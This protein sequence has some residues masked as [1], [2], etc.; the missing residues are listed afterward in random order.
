MFNFN[1]NNQE[2]QAVTREMHR[3]CDSYPGCKG[4]P[5]ESGDP[6]VILGKKCCCVTAAM[7]LGKDGNLH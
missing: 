6:I 4:C 3:I 2:D 5:M 7:K 1:M